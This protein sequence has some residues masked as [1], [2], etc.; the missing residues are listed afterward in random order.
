M[1][2]VKVPYKWSIGDTANVTAHSEGFS[3]DAG[4]L[5][6]ARML[7]SPGSGLGSATA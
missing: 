5:K 3:E 6:K 4:L 1:T 7:W 2:D